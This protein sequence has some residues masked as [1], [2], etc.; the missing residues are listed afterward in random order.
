MVKVMGS[1]EDTIQSIIALSMA[2]AVVAILAM[3]TL[4]VMRVSTVTDCAVSEKFVRTD[5]SRVR[6]V[7]STC[8][9]YEV[10]NSALDGDTSSAQ[11]WDSLEIGDSYDF[12]LRG[13]RIALFG[14]YPNIVSASPVA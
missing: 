2:L 9:T 1:T 12:T 3:S 5:G 11:R 6:M 4:D 13:T 10:V 8:G 7:R 14:M